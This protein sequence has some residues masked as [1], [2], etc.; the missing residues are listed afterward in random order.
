MVMMSNDTTAGAPVKGFCIDMLEKMKEDLGFTYSLHLV[1]D[2]EFGSQDPETKKW[3]GMVA[4][5]LDRVRKPTM[6][7]LTSSLFSIFFEK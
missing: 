7:C 6:P 1:Y 3:N 4:E 2:G 5:L